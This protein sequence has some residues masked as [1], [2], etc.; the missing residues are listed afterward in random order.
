M[1]S[2]PF[3]L[4][5]VILTLIGAVPAF[6]GSLMP[7]RFREDRKHS[8]KISVI[9]PSRNEEMMIAHV[10]ESWLKVDYPRD[11]MEILCVDNSNDGTPEIIK[12]YAKK[13][14][15]VRYL[16]GNT[17]SKLG[18]ILYAA[19]KARNPIVLISDSDV[20]A[21]PSCVRESVKYLADKRVGAVFGKRTPVGYKGSI[22][23]RWDAFRLLR[24]FVNHRFFSWVD[25]TIYFSAS[26]CTMRKKDIA[27]MPENDE[28]IADDL[29]MALQIRKKGLKVIFDH[30]IEGMVGVLERMSEVFVRNP[31]G[32]KGTAEIAMKGYDGM[33]GRR[34]YGKFGLL[35]LPFVEFTYLGNMILHTL[36]PFTIV[37]D[38]IVGSLS[39]QSA[40]LLGYLWSI[41]LLWY[42]VMIL[43][44][45]LSLITTSFVIGHKDKSFLL[46]IFMDPFIGL[47]NMS[48]SFMGFYSYLFGRKVEWKKTTTD[49]EIGK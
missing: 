21:S 31:R 35:I 22:F 1:I 48:A 2:W 20:L 9:I 14:S 27:D 40:A 30:R 46:V 28:L 17:N 42:S 43:R 4:S 39:G 15:I 16:T 7:Y 5:L 10:I 47:V 12:G 19:K 41:F 32:A 45:L 29:Y 18:A 25:S 44:N 49:R 38:V 3:I 6:I 34:K 24:T 33:L 36:I 23:S 37:A 26:P 13:H 11:R 8:P